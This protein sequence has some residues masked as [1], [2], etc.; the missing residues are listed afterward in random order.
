MEPCED[1][2]SIE[3]EVIESPV[4]KT[5]KPMSQEALDRLA[6]ARE[7]ASRRRQEMA[8]E[9]KLDK[10]T[11]VQSKMEEEM[12][13]QKAKDNKSAAKEAKRRIK[14]KQSIII[15]KSGSDSDSSEDD[16]MN[17]K[18]YT[19]RRKSTKPPREEHHVVKDDPLD[20]LYSNLFRASETI[21]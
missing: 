5:R 2:E 8:A 7:K 18:V 21:L 12:Q 16:I 17:A 10:E 19:V 15:E 11:L 6:L 4:K 20:K 3:S 13:A 14:A 9:R 1:I